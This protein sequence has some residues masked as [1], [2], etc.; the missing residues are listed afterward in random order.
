[1]NRYLRGKANINTIAVYVIVALLLLIYPQWTLAIAFTGY[2]LS[3]P[4][5]GLWKR[6]HPPKQT[7]T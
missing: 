2:A 3:A 7:V 4:G 1:M 5:W 6:F